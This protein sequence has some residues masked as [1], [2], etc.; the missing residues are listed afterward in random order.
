MVQ[1]LCK[2]VVESELAKN[3]INP[4]IWQQILKGEARCKWGA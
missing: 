3:Y 4:L 2:G 1:Q